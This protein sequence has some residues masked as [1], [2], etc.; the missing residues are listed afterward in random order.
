[1]KYT[2]KTRKAYDFAEYKHRGQLD[3][4]NKSYFE[5]HICQV[6][7]IL[8]RV[9]T[10][11]DIICAGLL[12]DTL[13]DTDTTFE[14]LE[15][16]FGLRVAK[17]VHEVT[18]DGQKDNYGYYF[19]RLETRDGILVKLADRASNVSRMECW[20]KERQEL[21]LKKTKFWKDGSDKLNV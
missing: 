18:H 3:D 17:L 21:Y 4:S 7:D 13:E 1:M 12:H 6:A 2:E 11:D 15:K 9:T 10:D 5:A 16:E 20:S 8:S 14:E 19:P